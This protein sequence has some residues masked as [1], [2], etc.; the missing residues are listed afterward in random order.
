MT[1][2]AREALRL[3]TT[4]SDAV[5]EKLLAEEGIRSAKVIEL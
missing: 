4:P 1:A 5:L 2:A 3:D